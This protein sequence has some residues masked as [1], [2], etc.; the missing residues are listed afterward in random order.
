MTKRQSSK[1]G[2]K[3]AD[4]KTVSARPTGNLVTYFIIFVFGFLAGVAFTVI[5]SSSPDPAST[6]APQE[7]SQNDQAHQ[8]ILNLEAEVTA[9]PDDYQAWVRLGHLYFDTDQPQKA[10]K[11]YT[12]GLELHKGDANLLT[13]LGVMYRRT[14]QPAKAVEYFDKAIAM[15]PVHMPSRFNKGIVLFYD[16]DDPEGAIG[17]WESLLQI[18]PEAKT[19]S[20]EPLGQFIKRVKEDLAKHKAEQH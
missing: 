14:N 8:A 15:D 7:H 2:G 16:L 18:D 1:T 13:D 19:S 17:S 5:R 6:P 9:N 4:Q 10:I 12:T 3:T 20:G 11:A